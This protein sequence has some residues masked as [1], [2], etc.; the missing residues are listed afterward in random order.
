MEASNTNTFYPQL[1]NYLDTLCK[2]YGST[3]FPQ[4]EWSAIIYLSSRNRKLNI[5][6]K[7]WIVSEFCCILVLVV[8]K[9]SG[10]FIVNQITPCPRPELENC[11]PG[12]CCH[13]H[14]HAVFHKTQNTTDFLIIWRSLSRNKFNY[15]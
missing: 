14:H 13:H 5:F 8:A 2:I 9:L 15:D 4:L 3:M 7:K 6:S 10:G 12:R 1:C 11:V